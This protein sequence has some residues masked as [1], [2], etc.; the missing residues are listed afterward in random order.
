MRSKPVQ[1]PYPPIYVGG[2]RRA[3]ERIAK[4]G[5]AWLANGLPPN[6]LEPMMGELREVAGRDVP[7]TVFNASSDQEDLEAYR[8]LDVERV[9]LGLPTLPESETLKQ[10]HNLAD[11]TWGFRP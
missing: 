11:P 10:L 5:D 4:F 8:R 9:L 7:V 6:K 3:F 1:K 2:G